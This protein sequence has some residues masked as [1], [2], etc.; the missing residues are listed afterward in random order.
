MSRIAYVNGQ[1]TGH[2]FAHVHI[3]DRG[4][5][6]ADGLYEVWGVRHGKLQ[7]HS[8]HMQRL[9]RSMKAMDIPMIHSLASLDIV[10]REVIRRNRV[11]NG[12]VYLQITRGVAP[13]DHAWKPEMFPSIVVT[14]KHINYQAAGEAA[15]IGIQVKTMDD[16][17]WKCCDIK[18]TSLLPNV[19]AKQRARAAG[20]YEAWL[21][22]PQG[23]I[24]E[25][26]ST[27]AWIV[28]DQVLIT[29]PLGRD[30]LSGVT[31]LSLIKIAKS[32]QLKVEERPF[33]LKEAQQADEAFI[34][35]AT[36]LVMPVI[37]IDG[38]P[39]GKGVPG[40]ISTRLRQAYLDQDC[41]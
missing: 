22:D 3:D 27:N 25:G 15:K 28:R 14:A 35:A 31:R 16:L 21:L 1:Y 39:V 8:A 40:P 33:S 2:H 38:Q 29:R 36:T 6:F 18:S 26:S 41:A 4:Y 37:G 9:E 13:R 19:L 34:T 10:L 23:N 7:D 32:L 24:T 30:I 20:A 5:Q 12:M 17:R 11:K